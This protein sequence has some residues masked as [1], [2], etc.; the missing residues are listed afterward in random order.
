MWRSGV[1]GL[2][3]GA[4]VDAGDGLI[5]YPVKHVWHALTRRRWLV[6][7]RCSVCAARLWPI[8]TLAY[9]RSGPRRLTLCVRCYVG[10][11]DVMELR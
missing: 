7:G 4:I 11:R 3:R 5:P 8:R 1:T 9:P 10:R 2:Q 6:P